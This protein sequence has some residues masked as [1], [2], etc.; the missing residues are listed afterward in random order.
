MC[1]FIAK[2]A[3]GITK[4]ETYPGERAREREVAGNETLSWQPRLHIKSKDVA[5][6]KIVVDSGI[7]IK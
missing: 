3:G 1:F 6:N 5:S 2:G 7:E 4:R